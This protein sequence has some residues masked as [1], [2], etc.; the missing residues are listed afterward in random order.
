MIGASIL[1][2][3]LLK[4]VNVSYDIKNMSHQLDTT[5]KEQQYESIIEGIGIFYLLYSWMP[6]SLFFLA[7]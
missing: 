1:E 7:G 3:Y 5:A 4:F 6:D 2:M